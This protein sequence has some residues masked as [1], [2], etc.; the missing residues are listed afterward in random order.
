M[1]VLLN[2]SGYSTAGTDCVDTNEE[3]L[4][5]DV[6]QEQSAGSVE[7][8]SSSSDFDFL[9]IGDTGILYLEGQ[10][11]I[12]VGISKDAFDRLMKLSVAGDRE[13]QKEMLYLSPEIILVDSGTKIR[14]IDTSISTCEIR[15]LDGEYS[16]RSGFTNCNFLRKSSE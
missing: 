1:I 7:T 5:P 10:E 14:V 11:R 8:A 9:I 12:P 15:I 3:F 16:G 2:L 6:S 4:R 13:G